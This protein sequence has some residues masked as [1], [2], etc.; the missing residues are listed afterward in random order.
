MTILLDTPFNIGDM[1]KSRLDGEYTYIVNNINITAIDSN[2]TVLTY[3][4]DC[5]DPEGVIRVFRPYEVEIV[6][7][8][9]K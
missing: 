4:L 9:N 7:S 5:G 1:V 6:E 2:G 8:V 3:V